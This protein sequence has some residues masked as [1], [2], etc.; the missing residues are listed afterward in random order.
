MHFLSEGVSHFLSLRGFMALIVGG[1]QRHTLFEKFEKTR[2][3]P[4]LHRLSEGPA[5]NRTLLERSR[6]LPGWHH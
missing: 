3:N 4:R 2:H 5:S 6:R 1:M